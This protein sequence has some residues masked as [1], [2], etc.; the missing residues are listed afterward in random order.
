MFVK[1]QRRIQGRQQLHSEYEMEKEGGS[2]KA[3][4]SQGHSNV[5]NDVRRICFHINIRR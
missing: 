4:Y 3:T 1:Q 5:F 2:R